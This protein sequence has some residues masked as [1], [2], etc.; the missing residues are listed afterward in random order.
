MVDTIA[1][2]RRSLIS[3]YSRAAAAHNKIT[4]A[5]EMV[6]LA[7]QDTAMLRMH[8][9]HL[10]KLAQWWV[11]EA[12]GKWRTRY[13][14]ATVIHLAMHD[15]ESQTRINHEHVYGRAE[16][17]ERMM[18]DPSQVDQI[19]ELCVGCVVT[20]DEHEKLSKVKDAHGWDR[21]KVAEVAVCDMALPH[22]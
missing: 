12:D 9:K 22:R 16:V 17:A 14:S 3:P 5:R 6:T 13:R 18:K 11:T 15:P 1:K 7:L 8:R 21:Y 10:L 2:H 20:V 4:S 19:L